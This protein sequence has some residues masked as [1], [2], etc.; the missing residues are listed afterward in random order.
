V[1]GLSDGGVH[2][3]VE[4]DLLA[5]A[6]DLVVSHEVDGAAQ[7]RRSALVEQGAGEVPADELVRLVVGVRKLPAQPFAVE[8][9]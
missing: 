1:V 2:V 3:A 4:A 7:I 9:G 6:A 5:A 8:A